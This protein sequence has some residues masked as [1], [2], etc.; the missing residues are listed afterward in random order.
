MSRK[1]FIGLMML[2]LVSALAGSCASPGAKA[3]G[4]QLFKTCMPCH[5]IHGEGDLSLRAPAIAGLPEW[6][7]TATITKFQKDIRGA[8]PDDM[9]GHRMRPM[10]RTLYHKGDVEG[11]VAHVASMKPTWVLPTIKGDAVAGQQRYTTLCI[12]CHGADGRAPDHSPGRLV[13]PGAA[14]EVQDR[15]A[16]LASAR[17]AGRHD[18]GDVEHP[19]R[20]AGDAG[21]RRLH[22]D[23]SSLTD[24]RRPKPMADDND[25]DDDWGNSVARQTFIWTVILSAL[26][27]G[28]VFIFILR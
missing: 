16:R 3:H 17:H 27:V 12:A 15:H 19:D 2:A 22:Q 28:C 26:F 10:A 6:Y 13:P 25:R 9:E 7:L 21:C 14:R 11:V 24:G 23:A 4:A 20:Y 5:G 1:A 18:A 8:H